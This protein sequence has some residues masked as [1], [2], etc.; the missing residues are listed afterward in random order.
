M[1]ST[2]IVVVTSEKFYWYPQGFP[3]LDNVELLAAYSV[4]VLSFLATVR[5]YRLDH[6][7]GAIVGSTVFSL[8]VEGSVTPVMYEDGPLPILALYF[9][10][11]H[12][13]FSVVVGWYGFRHLAIHGRRLQ[14]AGAATA[15]GALVGLWSTIYWLPSQIA[16]MRADDDVV[17]D[18][19]RWST[20]KF[21]V[22]T[23]VV[24]AILVVAHRVLGA[25]WP[26]DWQISRIGSGVLVTVVVAGVL[27]WTVAVFYAPIKFVVFALMVR[28]LIVWSAPLERLEHI[29]PRRSLFESL[30]G[31]TSWRSVAPIACVAPA[32][33]ATYAAVSVIDPPAA[34]LDIVYWTIVAA[35][36]VT[37]IAALWWAVRHRRMNLADH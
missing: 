2:V 37:G 13:V 19:G 21:G 23:I 25:V 32:A 35:T 22:Y 4:G 34:V 33:T 31:P 12:G 26:E 17:W 24:T 27:L 10:G 14:L 5:R 30:A 7:S 6:V 11:W 3:R 8:V 1:A 18:A 28:F 15:Y 20:G 36:T 16:G 9:L 29:P